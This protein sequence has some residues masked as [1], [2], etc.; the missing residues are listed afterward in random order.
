MKLVHISFRFEYT[1]QVEEILDEEGVE[2]FVR[3]PMMEGLDQD[4][5]HYGSQVFP[6]SVTVMQAL[7]PDERL[8]GVLDRLQSFRERKKA[9]NHLRA[10]VLP[11]EQ[12]IGIDE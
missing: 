5:K 10:A 1:D 4:G 6:G 3:Y 8:Q 11:V 9:H 12:V 2:D 7:V